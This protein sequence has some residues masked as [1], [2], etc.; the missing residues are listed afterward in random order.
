[1]SLTFKNVTITSIGSG[2]PL[3]LITKTYYKPG[4]KIVKQSVGIQW[5]DMPFISTSAD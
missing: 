4:Y 2:Y 3:Y 5:D 1:M